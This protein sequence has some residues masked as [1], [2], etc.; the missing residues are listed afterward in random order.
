M[1]I[2]FV[3]I[4]PLLIF[5]LVLSLTRIVSISS[6]TALLSSAI[7]ATI[8]DRN[9][10]YIMMLWGMAAFVIWRHRSNI[11]KILKGEEGKVRW[12]R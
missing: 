12:L 10:P 5:I 8:T 6:M 7:I 11:R 4:Y 9:I 1:D 2:Y 3:F